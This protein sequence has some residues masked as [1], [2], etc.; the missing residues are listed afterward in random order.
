M[1][2][3]RASQSR[4]LGTTSWLAPHW[5]STSSYLGPA[6]WGC[7]WSADKFVFGLHDVLQKYEWIANDF[8]LGDLL[9]NRQ[10]IW[11]Q[12][13]CVCRAISAFL[14]L[15]RRASVS[16]WPLMP[17]PV[18]SRGPWVWVWHHACSITHSGLI[19]ELVLKPLMATYPAGY[20]TGTLAE[21][22]CKP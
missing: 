11:P 12:W 6:A 18:V 17:R 13:D 15:G 8:K 2:G 14:P 7:T 10:Q 9:E 1:C 22:H 5:V 19:K 16:N 21:E 4:E 3:W 20:P